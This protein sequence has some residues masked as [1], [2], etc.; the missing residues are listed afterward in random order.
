MCSVYVGGQKGVQVEKLAGIY[1]DSLEMKRNSSEVSGCP[2]VPVPTDSHL[3]HDRAV[4]LFGVLVDHD[5]GVQSR[6]GKDTL[7]T[8]RT[9][10]LGTAGACE[11]DGMLVVN[12]DP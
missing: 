12:A 4:L 10:G 6:F 1:R 3:Q 11:V 8:R 2:N 5:A 9:K 7:K